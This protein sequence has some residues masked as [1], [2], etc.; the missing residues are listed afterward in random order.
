MEASFNCFVLGERNMERLRLKPSGLQPCEACSLSLSY[1]PFTWRD[2]LPTSHLY[3]GLLCGQQVKAIHLEV[4]LRRLEEL[5]S[6]VSG[7]V[8]KS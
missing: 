6:G 7:V 4:E 1:V 5:G 8:P 2:H 3:P